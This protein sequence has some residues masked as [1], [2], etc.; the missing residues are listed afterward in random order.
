MDASNA[1]PGC[2][3]PLPKD[4]DQSALAIKTAIERQTRSK[5]GR[6]HR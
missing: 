2:V 1:P 5:D 3:T 6:H 4:P